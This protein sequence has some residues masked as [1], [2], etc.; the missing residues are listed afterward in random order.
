MEFEYKRRI[1]DKLLASKLSRKGA[2]LIQGA[3]WCGKTTTAE[4]VAASILY[5]NDP[6]RINQNISL[7][8]INP[9][10]LLQGDNPRLIDEWQLAPSLWDTVRFEVDHRKQHGLFILT[11]SAVPSKGEQKETKHSGTGRFSWLTMRPM[12]LWESKESDGSVSLSELF[13]QPEQIAGINKLTIQDLAFLTCRGGWPE[14][15]DM[16]GDDALAQAFD[17]FDAVVN[18]D[19]SRVDGVQRAPERTKVLMRSYARHQGSMAPYTTIRND[20]V[21]NDTDKLDE[22]TVASYV[23][24][25]KKIFVIEDMRAWNPNLR[26]KTAI[27]TSDNRYFTDSSIA[28]AAMGLGPNDLINDL[29]TFGLV[30]ETMCMRDLRVYAEAMDG[31]V[32]HYRD[33]EGLECDAIVHLRNSSYGLI[34]IKLGG[35]TKIEEGAQA[36]NSL[37]DKLDLSKMKSPSFKMILTGTE[38]YA[39]RRKDGIY[40]VPIGCLKD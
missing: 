17:Y 27:R 19:I 35:H 24:A 25:L 37:E 34:E 31:D 10:L 40:V 20:M 6:Q 11:G 14:A 23:K 7:A 28:T 12:S 39:Y 29:E 30:F 3:K 13:N 16:T 18:R 33:K 5:M 15:T 8:E 1:A 4:Q 2:V 38:S 9:Q 26:S 32:Y 21:A 22:E 36:L